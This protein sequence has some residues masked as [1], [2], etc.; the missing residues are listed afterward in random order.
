MFFNKEKKPGAMIDVHCHVLP[1]IDDGSS[2]NKESVEMIK[3]AWEQGVTSLIATPHFSKG[4]TDY[5]YEEV[6]KYCK[7]L[8]RYVQKHI[9]P[10][11]HIYTGQEININEYSL[12]RIHSGEIITLAE[13]NYILIEFEP[14]VTFHS[15]YAALHE[16]AMTPYFPV[17][18]HFERYRV[19]REKGRMEELADLGI[20]MQM[21]CGSIIGNQFDKNVKWC[22][23]MLSEGVVHLLGTDMHNCGERGPRIEEAFAWM[24]KNLDDDYIEEIT[25]LNAQNI[26]AHNNV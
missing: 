24:E 13:S 22:R 15:M 2:S 9:S 8:E 7:A 20:L 17:L 25:V 1:G 26:I 16:I 11:F 19:L 10:D 4:F 23:R 14:D 3:M 6:K 21:N 18:A 5:E 12:S